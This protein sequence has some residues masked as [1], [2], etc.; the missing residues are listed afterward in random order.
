MPDEPSILD[1]NGLGGSNNNSADPFGN[2]A[3]PVTASVD[4]R[5]GA[6][7]LRNLF[8]TIVGDAGRAERAMDRLTRA[9][10]R[11]TNSLRQ[12]GNQR[13]TGTTSTSGQIEEATSQQRQGVLSGI[14]SGMSRFGGSLKSIGTSLGNISPN[15]AMFGTT[16]FQIGQAGVGALDQRVNNAYAGM[17][18][19]DRLSVLFQQT[20]GIS[21]QQYYDNYRQ[22]LQQYRLGAGGINTLL[23]LQAQTGIK[24]QVQ[25]GSI[26]GL[27]AAS[28]YA[29]STQDFAQ[30]IRTLA[31]PMVNNRM[32]MTLGTGIYGP[33]GNQRSLTEVFQQVVRGAGLTNR[34]VI[35]SGK[36]VGSLTR[37]RLSS[38]GIPEDM[39]DLILQYAEENA[40]FQRKTGG[41]QG[42]Y[43][44]EQMSH[45]KL[46]GIERNFATQKEETERKSAERDE[47]FYNRQKDNMASL[48]RN[49]QA[50]IGLQQAIEERLSGL[51]GARISTRGHPLARLGKGLLGIGMM[52]AGGAMM[53]NPTAPGLSQL[54]G[55]GLMSAGAGQL[56][57]TLQGAA[58]AGDPLERGSS[59]GPYTY[60]SAR[61]AKNLG[62]LNNT[63]KARLARMIN[64]NPNVEINQGFRSATQQREMFYSRYTR[65]DE[66]TG[67]F[68]NG[69]YWKKTSAQPDAAPPGMSMHE[70]GLAVDLS[71]DIEWV[72]KNAEKYGLKTFANIGEPWHVQPS[73]LPNNRRDYEKMGAPWGRPL[74]AA[75]FDKTAKFEAKSWHGPSDRQRMMSARGITNAVIASRSGSS[76]A[77]AVLGISSPVSNRTRGGLVKGIPSAEDIPAGFMFRTTASYGGW[78]YYVPKEFSDA[79]LEALHRREQPAWDVG[80]ITNSHGTFYGGFSMN[81]YN[82]QRAKKGLAAKGIDTSKWAPNA[83]DTVERQ[84]MAA[85]YL[86]EDL[87]AH[88]GWEPIVRGTVDWPG[89]G[90]LPS[91]DLPEGTATSTIKSSKTG[92]PLGMPTRGSGTMVVNGGNNITLAPTI[93]IQSSG[94]NEA[95]ARRAAN[96]FVRIFNNDVKLSALRSA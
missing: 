92:D 21:Q 74:G 76:G 56:F 35:E 2:S 25:A 12:M 3:T 20:Q 31:N 81:D 9:V 71:G 29:Y 82:W 54:A 66:P 75:P 38:L 53:L 34:R 94:N 49:T 39:H 86:L 57:G 90:V 40:Q 5:R 15:K 16:L 36:Q 93:Y 69:S 72:Q 83:N 77:E 48:E 43:D 18:A 27:S 55:A 61:S 26:Q 50:L 47:K 67:V 11:T 68:W 70:L 19:N 46:M 51:I 23:A 59:S 89:V 58:P 65:S 1:P 4:S 45:R 87:W 60:T 52:A 63:F 44:P 7:A 17:L 85:K 10:Q 32:T 28:G 79:D 62:S 95:D 14:S 6:N 88:N 24:S 41:K 8:N 22:P 78:G 42:M 80:P 30:M 13:G 91:I 73:E 96:E 84:K 64:D 33:G 37:A